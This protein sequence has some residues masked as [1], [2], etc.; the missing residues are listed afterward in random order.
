MKSKEFKKLLVDQT[1]ILKSHW[2]CESAPRIRLCHGSKSFDSSVK[3]DP[4]HLYPGIQDH[5]AIAF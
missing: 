2:M 5:V 4:C 3:L 1:S